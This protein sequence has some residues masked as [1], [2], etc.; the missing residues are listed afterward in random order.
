MCL[1]TGLSYWKIDLFCVY[2]EM[3]EIKNDSM[4]S[5]KGKSCIKYIHELCQQFSKYVT[6]EPFYLLQNKFRLCI[7]F[8]AIFYFLS[9]LCSPEIPSQLWNANSVRWSLWAWM[10]FSLPTFYFFYWLPG[11]PKAFTLSF[12]K[13]RRNI[14]KQ[15]R[16]KKKIYSLPS[17]ARCQSGNITDPFI[18]K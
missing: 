3:T 10:S 7:G 2:A 17:F 12:T 1:I 8:F 4:H 16:I 5:F 14:V 9:H 13:A 15:C 11:L 6:A 18:K